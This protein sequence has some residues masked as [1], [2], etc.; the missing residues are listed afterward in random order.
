MLA[1]QSEIDTGKFSEFVKYR[2]TTNKITRLTYNKTKLKSFYKSIIDSLP[3][4]KIINTIEDSKE[5]NQTDTITSTTS[6]EVLE[7]SSSIV[8]SAY[9][10]PATDNF[11]IEFNEEGNFKVEIY[12]ISGRNIKTVL[13]NSDRTNIA[14]KGIKPGTYYVRT[15][16]QETNESALIKLIVQL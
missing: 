4:I 2:D 5:I 8:K 3:T 11:N 13:A 15:T 7:Q 12:D 14:L 1:L 16:E 6:K 9:P 10:N